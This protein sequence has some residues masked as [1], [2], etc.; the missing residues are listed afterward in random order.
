[1]TGEAIKGKRLETDRRILDAATEVFA[2]YGF[3]GA[4]VDEIAARAGVNKATIYYHIGDKKKLYAEVTHGI[5][6]N[7]AEKIALIVG[8]S[9]HPEEKFRRYIRTVAET[10]EQN[11]QKAPIIMREIASGAHHIPDII[12]EDMA[13]II[14]L[15]SKILEQGKN[16]GIFIETVPFTVHLM[17]IGSLLLYRAGAKIRE[18]YQELFHLF[19]EEDSGT[20]GKMAR[21]LEKL[22]V[23]A[24]TGRSSV[25]GRLCRQSPRSKEEKQ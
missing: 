5:L 15:L 10:M 3:S 19:T 6:G 18:K 23:Y 22:M 7:T 21:E 17:V 12:P 13:R 25:S 24:V 9:I 14:G 8:D 4:R 20:P 11:P 2:E 1:M 16:E